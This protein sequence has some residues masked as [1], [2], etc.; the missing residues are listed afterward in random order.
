MAGDESAPPS[1]VGGAGALRDG[2]D[3]RQLL[4]RAEKARASAFGAVA[5]IAT[6]VLPYLYDDAPSS[7]AS[8]SGPLARD[9]AAKG[10]QLADALA[11]IVR[12]FVGPVAE[13][14][15]E[16][17]AQRPAAAPPARAI[18]CVASPGQVATATGVL[19]ASSDL[20]DGRLW[21]TALHHPMGH[22]I[23]S[24]RV[25]TL[26]ATF[27]S[28]AEGTSVPFRV[29]IEVPSDAVSGLYVGTLFCTVVRQEVA[30]LH[31]DVV[32]DSSVS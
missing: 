29:V 9:L 24:C 21:S 16:R 19:A 18:E 23:D 2:L 32:E 3:P 10:D 8:L 4:L 27:R 13:Y 28:I 30:V 1:D 25:R 11:S 7:R 26:P 6:S 31:L 12:G 5:D 22:R 15:E 20:S 14:L 17:A